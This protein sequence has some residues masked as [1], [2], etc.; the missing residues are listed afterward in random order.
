[1]ICPKCQHENP[2]QALFCLK[3]GNELPLA[4]APSLGDQPTL[5]SEQE[6]RSLDSL[7]TQVPNDAEPPSIGDLPT[8][9]SRTWRVGDKLMGR[10]RILGELGRGGMGVV[11]RCLDEVGGIEVALKALPPELS[12]NSGEMEEVKENFQIVERLHHPNIAA[13]KT[14][15][16]DA[17]SGDYFLILELAE[18]MDLRKW[19]KQTGGKV[20]LA[21]SSAP[22]NGLPWPK[23]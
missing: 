10:Y 5:R 7:P 11:Y 17:A 4:E 15:E 9:R 12:H 20:P 19:R 1:M 22:V 16:H 8:Q 2:P 21:Q 3:C 23:T 18:G 14:L 6:P 13:V